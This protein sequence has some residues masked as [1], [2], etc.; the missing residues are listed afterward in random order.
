MLVS[1]HYSSREGAVF[2]TQ[3]IHTSY[4]INKTYINKTKTVM[5]I[6]NY[7]A[8]T[9]HT[10]LRIDSI[11]FSSVADIVDMLFIEIIQYIN[12]NSFY[13]YH[14]HV[15]NSKSHLLLYTM[16][17]YNK[18]TLQTSVNNTR[19]VIQSYLQLNVVTHS[20]I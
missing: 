18:R 3:G 1:S 7:C 9:I 12:H 13:F 4:H 5:M 11:F 14:S 19:C 10:V 8:M 6:H 15:A 2:L 20:F 17:T 16:Y